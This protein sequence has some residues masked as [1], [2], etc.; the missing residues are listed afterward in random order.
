MVLGYLNP[1][2]DAEGYIDFYKNQYDKYYRPNLKSNLK[3]SESGENSLVQR[4]K[5]R[6]LLA[7][8]FRNILDIGSG[9]GE[10]LIS[11]SKIFPDAKFS[12]IEPS[13]DSQNLLKEKGIEVLSDDVNSNWDTK[14][15][16]RFDLLIMRHILEHFLDPLT[17]LKR[18][19]EV[20]SEDGVLYIA[21]PN[22]LNPTQDLEKVWFRVV[23]TYYFN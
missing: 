22:N 6:D 9:A 13:Q 1:R 15:N 4:F 12:A 3:K 21:V 18:I 14:L 16:E 10:N 19:R 17:V 7:P 20:L 11:F 2:W 5:E 23:H 8:G